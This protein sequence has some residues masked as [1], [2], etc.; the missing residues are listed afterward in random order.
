MTYS[1]S[2]VYTFTNEEIDKAIS[3]KKSLGV[4]VLDRGKATD[5]FKIYYVGRADKQ[6]LVNRL[7]DYVGTKYKWF[8]FDYATSPKNAFDKEC[9]IYHDHKPPDNKKHP[10][11]P[12]GTNWQC[13][14]CDVFKET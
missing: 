14:R 9:E 8:R 2:E 6:P 4:Y 1:L 3:K 13:P 10:E 12:D 5:D 7:K 11:R